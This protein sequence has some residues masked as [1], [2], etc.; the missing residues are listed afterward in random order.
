MT[1]ISS[2][3]LDICGKV[4]ELIEIDKP[5]S[6]AHTPVENTW[7]IRCRKGRNENVLGLGAVRSSLLLLETNKIEMGELSFIFCTSP[8]TFERQK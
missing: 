1:K 3:P 2:N 8:L 5:V 7:F 6:G 4:P